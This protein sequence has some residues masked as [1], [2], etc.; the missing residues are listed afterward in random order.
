MKHTFHASAC[1]FV[2]ALIAGCSSTPVTPTAAPSASTTAMSP[3]PANSGTAT[4]VASSA[5]ASVTLP[6]HLDPK[7]RIS[8]E[9]SVYF[10][11]DDFSVKSEFAGLVERQGR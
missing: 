2:G 3:S 11:F 4:P 8:T 7:S 5:V 6:P 1:L 9:R 10:D